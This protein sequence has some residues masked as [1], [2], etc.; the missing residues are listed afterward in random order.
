MGYDLRLFSDREAFISREAFPFDGNGGFMAFQKNERFIYQARNGE[1]GLSDVKATVRVDGSIVGQ[2]LPLTEVNSSELP[3]LYQLELTTAQLNAWGSGFYQ[4]FCN[5]DSK[6]APSASGR[7]IFESNDD[8][9]K[10][11]IDSVDGKITTVLDNQTTIK[12][13]LSGVK[14]VV[15]SNNQILSHVDY[16]NQNIKSIMDAIKSSVLGIQNN[17]RL[18][19][20]VPNQMVKPDSGAKVYKVNINLYDSAGN[21]E[22]PD[23]DEIKVT[24]TNPSGVVRNNLIDGF[25]SGNYYATKDSVGQYSFELQMTDSQICEPLSFAFDYVEEGSALNAMRAS[26]IVP[27]AQSSGLSLEGTSQSILADTQDM[28]PRI[29]EIQSLAKDATV[30]FS[31]L[32]DLLD[33]INIDSAGSIVKLSSAVY[34][35]EAI[36]AA[37]DNKASQTSVT[38]LSLSVD[39]AKG[40]GFD[41]NQHSLKIIA[42]QSFFGGKSF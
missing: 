42:E 35:L 7:N 30:G 38:A 11:S 36:K 41:T 23:A 17:T 34:G 24:I 27:E 9:L 33:I 20:S 28:K 5:S 40:V 31:A 37:V 21:L 4:V 8:I 29:V 13:D 22:D 2:N 10:S 32:K 12:T 6:D 3:G 25:V 39:D 18:T 15:E 1:I 19:A 26:E 14:S 16:G